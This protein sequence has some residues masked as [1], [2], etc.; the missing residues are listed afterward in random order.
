MKLKKIIF[1]LVALLIAQ[2]FFAWAEPQ[3]SNESPHNRINFSVETS[4]EV[5]EDVLQVTLFTQIEQNQLAVANKELNN[6]INQALALLKQ[7]E[8]KISIE[9]NTRSTYVRHNNQGK[10]SG[11]VVRGQ[12][13]LVSK[14][15][16]I[17]SQAISQLDHLMA[18]DEMKSYVSPDKIK[19]VEEQLMLEALD[20]FHHQ[21]K[22]IQT[23]LHA[24]QYQLVELHIASPS[25]PQPYRHT[26]LRTAGKNASYDVSDIQLIQGKT[27]LKARVE[28]KIEL[29]KD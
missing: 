7:Y 16:E 15:S 21:A 6:K 1:F 11:W 22:L 17:L 3:I 24:K 5:T 28:G 2:P 19:Q 10:Q 27:E 9:N 26:L 23:H 13:V 20:K 18:I 14:D 29:I 4:R 8:G 25:D 12:F